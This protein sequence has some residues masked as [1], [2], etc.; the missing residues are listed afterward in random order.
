MLDDLVSVSVM[1]LRRPAPLLPLLALA[2]ARAAPAPLPEHAPA[3]SPTSA[4]SA[5][6]SAS[7]ITACVDLTA[8]EQR[9]R[10]GEIPAC[11]RG[12][13]AAACTHDS[14]DL[15]RAAPLLG[16]ACD[17]G[18]T[19]ACT[20]LA[21]AVDRGVTAPGRDPEALYEAACAARDGGACWSLA[22]RERDTR[23]VDQRVREHRS[24]FER[25]CAKG[26]LDGCLALDDYLGLEDPEEGDPRD[27]A[28]A[29]AAREAAL[30]LASTRCAG[31]DAG[32]C[33]MAGSLLRRNSPIAAE[34]EQANEKLR[35]GLA[36]RERRCEGGDAESCHT[37]ASALLMATLVPRDEPR[38]IALYL[39]ACA[40]GIADGCKTMAIKLEMGHGVPRDLEKANAMY[41]RACALC[42]DDACTS[43]ARRA[44][45][46][47]RAW[48]DPEEEAGA[49]SRR[50]REVRH[51]LVPFVW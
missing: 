31:D 37:V 22:R 35:R 34:R 20:E 48:E 36:L 5:Q 43:A 17:R 49:V 13:E 32:A 6:P 39:R 25:L 51:R 3:P 41:E 33:E 26:F 12:A 46:A 16:I 1:L 50:S 7:V 15:Q 4:A 27:P 18:A 19:E 28:G 8:C 21:R 11:L 42:D 38:A 24:L 30:R 40:G 45:K 10:G 2:C 23:K 44:Q 9:C 29:A 14:A 47:G